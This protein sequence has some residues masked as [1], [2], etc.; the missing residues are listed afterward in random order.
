MK[1]R[2]H[3]EVVL[4]LAGVGFLLMEMFV[5]PGFGIAGFCGITLI[6]LSLFMAGQRFA[7]EEGISTNEL[8]GSLLLIA[9]AG[10][11]SIVG[12]YVVSQYFGGLRLF[13]HL[14]LEPPEPAVA[15]AGSLATSETS[16]LPPIEIGDEGVADSALRPSGRVLFGETYRDVVTDGSF[17]DPGTRVRVVKVAGTHI[18]V[19]EVSS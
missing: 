8:S 12:M 3:F 6:L 18:T 16:S 5:I 19:R 13:K 1:R 4:F 11:A 9:G 17:V 10:V 15:A 2:C 7:G 14:T